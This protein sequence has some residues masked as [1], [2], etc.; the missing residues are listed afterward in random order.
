MMKSIYDDVMNFNRDLRRVS[1]FNI[2]LH[3]IKIGKVVFLQHRLNSGRTHRVF[4][5]CGGLLHLDALQ[6]CAVCRSNHAS[7]STYTQF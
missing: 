4:A 6:V 5:R 2:D 1:T 7:E 3:D